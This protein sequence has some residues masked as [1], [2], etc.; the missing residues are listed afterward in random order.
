MIA[1]HGSQNNLSVKSGQSVSKK[2]Q[3]R[4]SR[5]TRIENDLIREICVIRVKKISDTDRTDDTD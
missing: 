1:R 5:M 2:Y 3:T 4:I